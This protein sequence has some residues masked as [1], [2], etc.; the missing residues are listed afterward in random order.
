MKHRKPFF[1]AICFA[2]LG[3]GAV[4]AHSGATGIVKERMDAMKAIGKAM[5]SLGAMAKGEAAFDAG[6]VGAASKT[7]S[8]HAGEFDRLFPDTKASRKSHVTEAAP[9]IWTDKPA[10]LALAKDLVEAAGA[11]ETVGARAELGAQ[12]KALGATC[13]GCHEKFRI[14]KN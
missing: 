2:L 7:I 8:D 5:K 10:F 12:M 9:A 11:L 1:L 4:L 14:K 13:K 3:A 6:K